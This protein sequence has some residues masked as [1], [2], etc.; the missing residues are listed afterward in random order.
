MQRLEG[1]SRRRLRSV[2][3]KQWEARLGAV[4]RIAKT[5][6]GTGS[7]RTN[8]GQRSRPVAAGEQPRAC[9]CAAQCL[10]RLARDSAIH[11]R[12][13]AQ[14]AEP[15]DADPHIRWCDKES[16]R[17]P[18]Y[19]DLALVGQAARVPQCHLVCNETGFCTNCGADPLVRAGPPGPALRLRN[20]SLNGHDKPTR[21][22]PAV[23]GDRPTICVGVRRWETKWHGARVP[24]PR[25][26]LGQSLPTS[27]WMMTNATR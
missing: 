24:A 1:W 20:Q 11:W 21:A 15:P 13:I 16:G 27:Q 4:R 22:S 19:V 25:L 2:I 17:P 9:L 10:L 14:P 5:G 26:R 23:Q 18:T 6:S 3:W 7:R 8:G 12:P